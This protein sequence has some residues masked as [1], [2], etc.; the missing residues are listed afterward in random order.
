MDALLAILAGLLV[1]GVVAW[2]VAQVL[3]IWRGGADGGDE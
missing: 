3:D 2:V 1:V